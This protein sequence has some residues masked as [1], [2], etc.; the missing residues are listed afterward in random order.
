MP[1]KISPTG[2]LVAWSGLV[3]LN[4]AAPI[5]RIYCV[6][7]FQ[8]SRWICGIEAICKVA[9]LNSAMDPLASL[10]DNNPCVAWC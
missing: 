3:G 10:T 9:P 1:R 6:L 7:E 4:L 8:S 5:P 2:A